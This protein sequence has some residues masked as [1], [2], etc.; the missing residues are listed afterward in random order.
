MPARLEVA[1]PAKSVGWNS[2]VAAFPPAASQ[3][4]WECMHIPVLEHHPSRFL[5]RSFEILVHSRLLNI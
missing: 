4:V 2:M 1:S 5:K 3:M